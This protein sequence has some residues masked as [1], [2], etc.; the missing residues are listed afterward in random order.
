MLEGLRSEVKRIVSLYCTEPNHREA[1][2]RA[3]AQ[4]GFALHPRAPCR[5]GLLSLHI[6][7]AIRGSITE[8]ALQAASAVELQMEAAYLFDAVA[9][10]DIQPEQGLTPA[11]V[12]ALAIAILTCGSGGGLRRGSPGGPP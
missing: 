4:S 7:Q 5:A 1:M 8:I 2:L 6:Y 3:L 9:D 10:G 11:E 12:L